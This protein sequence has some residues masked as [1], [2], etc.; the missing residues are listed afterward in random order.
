MCCC[1]MFFGI[2]PAFFTAKA[3][4]PAWTCMRRDYGC[5]A[6][7]KRCANRRRFVSIVCAA[8]R[9][10]PVTMPPASQRDRYD[11]AHSSVGCSLARIVEEELIAI[12]IVDHN[13]PVTPRTFLNRNTPGLELRAQCIHCR[14][15]G[16]AR[17]GI[18]RN[19]YQPFA[20]LLR[21]LVGQ[22][23]RAALP[24]RL[25]HACSA[26]LFI[27]PEAGKSKPF[28]IKAERRI[29]VSNVQDGTGKPVCH[30][31]R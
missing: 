4:R 15:L 20:N 29:N 2:E 23:Q 30:R 18:Q 13:T 25:R 12:G 28:H 6:A 31:D 10:E 19:E 11:S 17:F 16:L 26:V 5:S 8:C 9:T 7:M 14:D 27:T 1:R 21:P 24:F 3:Q 22:D